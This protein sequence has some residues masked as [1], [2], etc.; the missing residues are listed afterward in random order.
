M[1]LHLIKSGIL[2]ALLAFP[3]YSSDFIDQNDSLIAAGALVDPVVT[4]DALIELPAPIKRQYK[5]IPGKDSMSHAML[6]AHPN[7]TIV[8]HELAAAS[9]VP[10]AFDVRSLDAVFPLPFDQGELGSCT[11]NALTGLVRYVMDRE[12]KPSEELSRIF[13]YYNERMI[14]GDIG[15]DSGASLSTGLRTLHTYGVCNETLCPYDISTFTQKPS[16]S[17]YKDGL[18]N[19]DL[20]NLAADHIQ[21]SL[22]AFKHTIAIAQRPFALGI[23]IYES[24]ESAAVASTGIVPMPSAT[25][26]CLGGHAVLAVGY[27]DEKGR[28][29]VRNSWGPDWGDNGYFYL[30]YAYVTNP[31]LAQDF[32]SIS[33]IGSRA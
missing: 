21:Q 2:S 26:S 17:A 20:D 22:A 24:F 3:G 15:E 18:A 8:T 23:Q 30:P 32:W 29:T 6:L 28:L 16:L 11:A 7:T 19:V 13:I 5:L 4:V 9:V 27:D 12:Q 10:S 14:E 25:E 31:D 33:K 1:R